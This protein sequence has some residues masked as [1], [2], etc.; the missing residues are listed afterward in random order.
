MKI[1]E[2]FQLRNTVEMRLA[3]S[4]TFESSIHKFSI[5]FAKQV[6]T[7]KKLF[8]KINVS[9]GFLFRVLFYDGRCGIIM[10]K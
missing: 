1:S 3:N 4:V 8:R 7:Q 6:D 2:L 5:Y 9:V 10:I